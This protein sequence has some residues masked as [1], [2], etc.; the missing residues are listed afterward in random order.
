MVLLLRPVDSNKKAANLFWDESEQRWSVGYGTLSTVGTATDTGAN[1]TYS[2]LASGTNKTFIATVSA[3][4]SA[5]TGT[6]EM[7]KNTVDKVGQIVCD[8][9]GDVWIYGLENGDSVSDS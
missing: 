1:F 8:A 6:P 2:N 3:S 5:P 7:G 9:N 4:T